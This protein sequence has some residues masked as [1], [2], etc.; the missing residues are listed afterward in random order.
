MLRRTIVVHTRLASHAARVEAARTSAHGLQIL[1]V[2]R[3]AARLAGGFLQ[4]I[5]AEALQDAVAFALNSIELGEL[6]DIKKLPGMVRAAVGTLE[7]VWQARIDLAAHPDEPRLKALSALEREVLRLLPASMKRPPELVELALA[8]VQHAK[9]VFG[10][11]EVHGHS[12]MAPIWRPLLQALAEVVPVD[13]IAGPRDIPKWLETTKI[14]VQRGKAENPSI[15]LYSCAN[16]QHEILEALRWARGLLAT[17][18]AKPEEI[19]IA[20]ASPAAFDD[21]MMA[22][23]REAN[24]PI[25]STQAAY[26]VV[27]GSSI[28][29]LSSAFEA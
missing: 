21:P 26:C 17:G 5:D 22:L 11:I 28:S 14:R 23:A 2:N 27:P 18:T 10:P 9:A 4:P 8:R 7:K 15:T 16:P 29:S 3:L 19:A 20:A 13:W 25:H 24:L 12:E 6:D 1:T